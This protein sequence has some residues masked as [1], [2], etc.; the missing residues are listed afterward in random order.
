MGLNPSLDPVEQG[1]WLITLLA[2][3][4]KILHQ[5]IHAMN[6]DLEHSNP[7]GQDSPALSS[8]Q[9]LSTDDQLG[10]LWVL[11]ENMGGSVTPAAP[12]AAA[13]QFTQTLLDEVKA[14]SHEDQLTFMRLLAENTPT[15]QTEQYSAFSEDNKLLFWYQLAEEMDAGTVV[16]MPEG[17]E[18]P[19]DA[20]QLFSEITAM[21]FN[22][23]IT[24]LRNA[25]LG[26]GA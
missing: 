10:L 1:L 8:F 4:Y 14:M 12:G 16:P 9:A 15:A 22:E 20:A 23:Q 6:T 2:D 17:Y 5:E 19:S 26:M 13:P 21:E 3:I 25:V 11:Y 7:I 18:L 24:L